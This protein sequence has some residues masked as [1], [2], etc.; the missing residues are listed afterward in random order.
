M[1]F[2][3]RVSKL[4]LRRLAPEHGVTMV[5]YGVVMAV[6]TVAVMAT[7]I[8]LSGGIVATVQAVVDI[9]T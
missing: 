7:F 9:L 5:E 1:P 8:A 2:M 3:S 4:V 6:I